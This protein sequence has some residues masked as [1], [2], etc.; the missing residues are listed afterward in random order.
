MTEKKK[1]SLAT[2]PKEDSPAVLLKGSVSYFIELRRRFYYEPSRLRTN[3]RTKRTPAGKRASE[4]ASQRV[5]LGRFAASFGVARI[6]FF[7]CFFFF[8]LRR[9]SLLAGRQTRLKRPRMWVS[10]SVA[11]ASAVPANEEA[12]RFTRDF[13]IVRGGSSVFALPACPLLS[14][15]SLFPTP[16][17]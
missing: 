2:T 17:E 1:F 8:F 11:R 12:I 16:G 15:A 4:R 13:V 9:F 5:Y 3:E 7:V 6:M 10:Q 14:F